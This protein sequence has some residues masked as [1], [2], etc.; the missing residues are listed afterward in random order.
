MP[1]APRILIQGGLYHA[2][3][4]FAR[5]EEVFADPDEEGRFLDLLRAP[6]CGESV[7]S[8]GR[9]ENIEGCESCGALD[10][11]DRCLAETPSAVE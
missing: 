6:G 4:R 3:N 8:P 2:N 7:G 5:G 11:L 9:G 10:Q 1:R